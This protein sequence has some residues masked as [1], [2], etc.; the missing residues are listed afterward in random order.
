MRY[1]NTFLLLLLSIKVHMQRPYWR[2][3][4]IT[5]INYPFGGIII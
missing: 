1:I 3:A 5:L 4:V 2:V